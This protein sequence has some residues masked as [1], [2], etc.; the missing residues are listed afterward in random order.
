MFPP[1][2]RTQRFRLTRSEEDVKTTARN[3][4]TIANGSCSVT[5]IRHSHVETH[6]VGAQKKQLNTLNAVL[7]PPVIS[8][9]YQLRILPTIDGGSWQVFA[10]SSEGDSCRG[11]LFDRKT[12]V[13][14]SETFETIDDID[15]F[16]MLEAF[17]AD[18]FRVIIDTWG[19]EVES[20]D[21]GDE[22]EA[23][24]LFRREIGGLEAQNLARLSLPQ[25]GI[26]VLSKIK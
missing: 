17:D 11:I 8:P 3:H 23:V 15:A 14:V 18:L 19:G 2:I 7:N 24:V 1:L 5:H 4:L 12:V 22:G 10:L 21:P 20:G 26:A 16:D 9:K 25:E 13:R 6:R